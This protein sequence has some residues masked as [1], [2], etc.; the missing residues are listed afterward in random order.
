M[1]YSA[2]AT[3]YPCFG[4]GREAIIE[5]LALALTSPIESEQ[6]VVYILV[7][8][9][10]LLERD[11][12]AKSFRAIQFCCDWAVHPVMDRADALYILKKLDHG[13]EALISSHLRDIE[14]FAKERVD[15]DPML[16]L[17]SDLARFLEKYSLPD[18][19]LE[20]DRFAGFLNHYTRVIEDCPLT[21]E[22]KVN[23]L[24]H[25]A[26]V[27]VKWRNVPPQH[28]SKSGVDMFLFGAEWTFKLKHKKLAIEPQPTYFC[29]G[30]PASSVSPKSI[31]SPG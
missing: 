30:L 15:A 29:V 20:R 25:I 11:K 10:K 26:S 16:C 17:S 6:Q 8:I 12:N 2:R 23:D 19:I 1:V 4:M 22:D 27:V 31:D 28:Q 14:S 7:E 9:R 21:Y 13:I 18:G 3:G 24:R 5:K